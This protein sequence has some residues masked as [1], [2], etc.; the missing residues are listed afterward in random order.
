MVR[1]GPVTRDIKPR[2]MDVQ[3]RSS[4]D[5]GTVRSMG[6]EGVEWGPGQSR[7]LGPAS[8]A[9]ASRLSILNS[10]GAI[11]NRVIYRHLVSM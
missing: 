1:G 7:L 2:G 5:Q 11:G 4:C 10:V 3:P 6:I 9:S 8:V